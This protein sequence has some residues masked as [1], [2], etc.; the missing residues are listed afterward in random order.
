MAEFNRLGVHDRARRI[1]TT[2]V[3]IERKVD[4]TNML[5]QYE[6]SRLI[7]TLTLTGSSS[8]LEMVVSAARNHESFLPMGDEP[9]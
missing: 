4:T 7:D 6:A 1:E 2:A 8:D 5:K 9:A 3:L